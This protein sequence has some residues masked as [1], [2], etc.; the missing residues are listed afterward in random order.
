MMESMRLSTT[1]ICIELLLTVFCCYHEYHI[2]YYII[3]LCMDLF[4]MCAVLLIHNDSSIY[5]F[6]CIFHKVTFLI[7]FTATQAFEILGNLKKDSYI[8]GLLLL[9]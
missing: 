6:R 9:L 1:I 3:D 2:L 8:Y 7:K 5:M 4:K